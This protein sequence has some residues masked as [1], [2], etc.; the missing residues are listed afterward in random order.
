MEKIEPNLNVMISEALNGDTI[1]AHNAVV[2]LAAM[3]GSTSVNQFTG[4]KLS[5]PMSITPIA[6]AYLF[7]VLERILRGEKADAAFN[8]KRNGRRTAWSFYPKHK[9]A[10]M[11]YYLYNH[12]KLSVENSCAVVADTI[13][14]LVDR[15]PHQLLGAWGLGHFIAKPKISQ[16]LVQKWYYEFAGRLNGIQGRAL[17]LLM[18]EH[19]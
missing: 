14:D 13:N 4:E 10:D 3:L 11:A 2:M 12:E 16:E 7:N 15:T 18:S 6:R 9:A 8:L 19:L 5:E 17:R 1:A